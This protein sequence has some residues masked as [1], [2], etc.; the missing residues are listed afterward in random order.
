MLKS[1]FSKS[2]RVPDGLWEKAAVLAAL[3][4]RYGGVQHLGDEQGFGLYGVIDGELRFVVALVL[5]ADRPDLISEVG[6]M[7]RFTGF[8][9]SQPTLDSINRNLHISVVGLDPAGD[10][11]LIGGVQ[12]SGAFNEQRFSM[13]LDAWRRDV[14]VVIE[15]LS[16]GGVWASAFPPLAMARAAAF[17]ANAA[18]GESPSERLQTIRRF[19]SPDLRTMTLCGACGGRGKIGLI[20]RACSDCGGSGLERRPH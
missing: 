20:A 13:V 16:G 2:F 11:F 18:T 5:A 9:A 1:L 12:A 15:M 17:T 3:K 7:V 4:G 19:A 10:I 14:T 8:P 6:F